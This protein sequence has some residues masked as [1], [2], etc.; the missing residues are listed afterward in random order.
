MGFHLKMRLAPSHRLAYYGKK[1]ALTCDFSQASVKFVQKY[2]TLD[3]KFVTDVE[4]VINGM[5]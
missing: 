2:N 1:I 5:K 4:L 3:N